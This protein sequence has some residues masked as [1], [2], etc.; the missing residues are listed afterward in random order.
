MCIVLK[1]TP[2]GFYSS[3]AI[4]LKCLHNANCDVICQALRTYGLLDMNKFILFCFH[5]LTMYALCDSCASIVYYWDFCFF[6]KH[7][8]RY[9]M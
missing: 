5:R 8:P 3:L 9:N 7:V 4:A 6:I 2:C 1:T